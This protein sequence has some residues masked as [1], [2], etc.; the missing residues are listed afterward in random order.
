MV[1]YGLTAVAI[2]VEYVGAWLRQSDQPDAH[3]NQLRQFPPP[4]DEHLV[5]GRVG[6]CRA[7]H[8]HHDTRSCNGLKLQR[9]SRV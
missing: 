1:G 4:Q 5:L 6:I 8:T 7:L 9:S 2:I 3:D